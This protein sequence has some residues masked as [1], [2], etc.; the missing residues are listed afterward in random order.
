MND[1]ND[2]LAMIRQASGA[3]E[4]LA[5]G[6]SA[7][8][9]PLRNIEAV[10]LDVYGT[11]FISASGDIGNASDCLHSQAFTQT[12]LDAQ[13]YLRSEGVEGVRWLRSTIEDYHLQSRKNGIDYP[14]VDIVEVWRTTL[15]SLRRCGQLDGDLD[16]VDLAA[17][18]LRY[19]LATNPVWPMPGVAECLTELANRNVQLGVISNAQW[20][21]PLLFPVLLGGE[22]EALGIRSEM[23]FWSWR[24]GCAKPSQHLFRLAAEVLG[25]RGIEPAQVLYVGNDMLNDIA[26]ARS[27]GFRTAL[28]AGDQRSLRRRQGDTRVAGVEPDVVLTQMRDLLFCVRS[29]Q[30]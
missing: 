7:A 19:E 1:Y 15:R 24:A 25:G 3:I 5:T 22:L 18:S 11:M 2:Y 17:L 27:I 20:F 6:E 10:L 12:M 21:T 14:E 16:K 23:Q 29:H 28:F 13:L 8:L 4:P 9:K 30:E 26:P